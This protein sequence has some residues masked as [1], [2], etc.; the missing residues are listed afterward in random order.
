M[1][2]EKILL[3][4]DDVNFGMVLRS[5]LELN[6]FLVVL[7]QDGY[8]GLQAFKKESFAL[9]I[10][11]VMMP[12]MDGF[13]LAAEIRKTDKKIPLLFLTAK[14]L[15]EDI[16]WGYNLGADDYITKPFDTD[17]FLHKVKV[18]LKRV[19]ESA[20]AK[21]ETPVEFLIGK[22]KFNYKIRTLIFENTSQKLSPKEADLLAMLCMHQNDV[23]QRDEA[24]RKIWGEDSYFTT[25]SM[26]VFITKLRKYLKE[27]PAIEIENIHGN[28]FRLFVKQ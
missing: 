14:T 13:T 27:D 7:K 15:K 28:G 6:D 20:A 17:I 19:S 25:R 9:C 10:L 4:E 21:K 16:I 12:N 18:I 3:V 1:E 2:K 11:D 26:D 5:Y 24:L 8:Q 22:Y 23:L